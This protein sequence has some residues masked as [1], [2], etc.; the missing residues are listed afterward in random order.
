MK[1]KV[2]MK[3]IAEVDVQIVKMRESSGN[4]QFFI[5]L[6]RNDGEKSAFSTS[7]ILEHSC[8][9]TKNNL[10]KEECLSRAW[11]TA[12]FLARFVGLKSMNEVQLIGIDDAEREILVNSMTIFREA[13]E[14]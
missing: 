1:K 11:F 8:F 9:Q 5:R 12:G 14:D 2:A 7:G 6:S 13:D 3:K 10:T 4:E